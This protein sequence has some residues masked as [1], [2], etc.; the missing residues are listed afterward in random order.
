MPDPLERASKE[1]SARVTT[2][3]HELAGVRVALGEREREG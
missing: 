1:L 3:G 2:I